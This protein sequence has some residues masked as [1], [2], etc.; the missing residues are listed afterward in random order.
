[1][2]FEDVVLQTENVKPPVCNDHCEE[3][4]GKAKKAKKEWKGYRF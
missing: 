1:M 2:S 4:K 3:P